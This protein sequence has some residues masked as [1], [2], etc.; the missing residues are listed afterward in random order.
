M[1]TEHK[2]DYVKVN[3]ENSNGNDLL[4]DADNRT[5][6]DRKNKTKPNAPVS[7]MLIGAVFI[8]PEAEVALG[9]RLVLHDAHV[10]PASGVRSPADGTFNF[11]MKLIMGQW[12]A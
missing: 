4:D 3:Q 2:K 1:K 11:S 9:D 10:R 8:E 12:K 7:T 5:V 6:D